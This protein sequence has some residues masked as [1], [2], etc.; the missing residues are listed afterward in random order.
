MMH[1]Y[2]DPALGTPIE[3]LVYGNI[4]AADYMYA[5]GFI[6]SSD[7]NAK[8]RFV[9][10]SPK[11]ILEKV[12]EL[13]ITEWSFKGKNERH[14]GPMAQDF[15][16]AFGLGTDDRHIGTLDESGIALAAIQGLSEVVQ[17]KD[18]RISALEKQNVSLENRLAALEKL[19]VETTANGTG[20]SR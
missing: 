5:Q 7:R 4:Q 14:L 13:P 15:H 16:A 8:E 2:G 18:D 20:K 6:N 12:A 10:V 1:L 11:A 3:L 19:V 17:E 9:D